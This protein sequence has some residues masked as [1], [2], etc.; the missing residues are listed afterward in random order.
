M[1]MY[2]TG[3]Q[4]PL[5]LFN[6]KPI[7]CGTILAV[8]EPGVSL[9]PTP[10]HPGKDDV[11]GVYNQNGQEVGRVNGWECEYLITMRKSGRM[12]FCLSGAQKAA[13]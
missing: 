2:M 8:W 13:K 10:F 5:V 12:L 4:R 7:K 9:A 11:I 1:M 3:R 6:G